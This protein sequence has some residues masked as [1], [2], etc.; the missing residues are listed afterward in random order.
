MNVNDWL[1]PQWVYVGMT[2]G[3]MLI[4]AHKHGKPKEE[5]YDFWRSALCTLP[6]WICL[7][8]GG[9]FR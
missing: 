8:V 9:F 4:L 5:N 7:Y 1:W 3:G 6:T 2:F